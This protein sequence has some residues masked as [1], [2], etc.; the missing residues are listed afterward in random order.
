VNSGAAQGYIGRPF[1]QVQPETYNYLY[2]AA[3]ADRPIW[4]YRAGA[5]P[6]VRGAAWPRGVEE[7]R[8]RLGVGRPERRR[9][10]PGR[11]AGE[12]SESGRMAAGE[13]DATL[14]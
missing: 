14:G 9:L 3:E 11:T 4:Q 13:G 1:F 8:L 6:K 2:A 12:G 10:T 5:I 7:E